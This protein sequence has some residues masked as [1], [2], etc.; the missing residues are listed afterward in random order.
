M[1]VVSLVLV[2]CDR[3]NDDVATESDRWNNPRTA[4]SNNHDD[5][6]VS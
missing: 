6:D 3:C 5:S 1:V 4:G 2:L